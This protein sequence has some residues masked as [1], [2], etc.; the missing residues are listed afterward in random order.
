VTHITDR[1]QLKGFK[2]G[3]CWRPHIKALAAL[4]FVAL[5]QAIAVG[6][7]T[8]E[9]NQKQAVCA[10]LAAQLLKTMAHAIS[11]TPRAAQGSTA[12]SVY[13]DRYSG[14]DNTCSMAI[15]YQVPD[16]SARDCSFLTLARVPLKNDPNRG[17]M[18][19]AETGWCRNNGAGQSDYTSTSPSDVCHGGGSKQSDY[20]CV[21]A[22]IKNSVEANK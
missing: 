11:N 14:D 6:Q 15:E 4:L 22:F 5:V 10:M 16:N 1:I 13:G 8:D 3:R 19:V 7:S 18:K 21:Q 2:M 12:A 17:Q 9:S 20:N